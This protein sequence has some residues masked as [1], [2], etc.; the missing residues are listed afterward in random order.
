MNELRR[1]IASGPLVETVSRQE[2]FQVISDAASQNPLL[3]QQSSKRLKHMLDMFGTFDA[4][5]E[6]AAQKSLSLYIRQQAIIQFKNA[7]LGHWKS[8]KLLSDEHRG[9]IR[10]RSSSFIDEEDE[11]I[12][13]CNEVIVSKIARYD[14]PS[15]WPNLVADIMSIIDNNLQ[16]RYS[17]TDGETQST[18]VLR[19]SLQLLNAILKEFGSIKM[20]SGMKIMAELVEQLHLVLYNYYSKMAFSFSVSNVNLQNMETPYVY[21]N[22]LLAHLVFKC[23]VKIAVWL[24]S[25]MDKLTKEESEKNIAWFRELFES[26]AF[27]LQAL[28]NLRQNVVPSF[29]QPGP[30]ETLSSSKSVDILTRH[31]KAFGKFFRRL[32][33]LSRVRFIELPMCAD[34]ILFYWSQVVNATG[35]PSHYVADSNTAVYPVRFLVQ[36]MVLFKESLGQWTRTRRDGT[37]NRS[38]LSTEFVENAVKILITRFMP[39]NPSDLENWTRDPEEW[40]NLEDKENDQWEFEIRPCSER[41]L[42]QLSHQYSDIVTPLLASTF[43]DAAAQSTT[44]LPSVVQKEAL[45]CAIG[46]CAQRLKDVIPFNQWLHQTLAAEAQATNPNYPIIKRRI[47]WLLG[48]WV[49]ESCASPKDPTIWEILVHLLKDRNPGTDA[50]VRLTASIA[51]R[52]CIDTIEFD[53]EVFEPFLPTTVSELVRLMGEADTMESKGRINHTLNTV[54]EQSGIRIVPFINIITGPLP[55][56]W[57]AAGDDWLFKGSLLATVTRLVE[58]VKAN[59]TS[60]GPIIVPLVQES[61]SPGAISHLDEDGLNLWLNALRNTVTISSVDGA[62]ALI[63]LFPQAMELLATNL[64]LLGRITSIIESYIVLDAVSILQLHGI[65]LF[66]AF[67]AALKSD[68]VTINI[69]DMIVT[70]S[71]LI[72]ITPAALW[73]ESMYSSGLFAFLITTLVEGEIGTMLLTEYIYFFARIVMADRQMFLQLMVATASSTGLTEKYLFE[74]L[75]DQWWGKFDSMSEPRHRKLAAMGIACL[76]S[77]GRFE[78]LERLPTEIFNIWLDVFGE[79]KEIQLTTESDDGSPSPS[80]RNLRRYWELS[81][82]PPYYYQNTEGTPEYDRRKAIYENDPVRTM[83]LSVFVAN[84]LQEVEAVC[85]PA[86]FQSYLAKADPTVLKQIQ[87]ELTKT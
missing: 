86:V 6:I 17:S 35:G 45:Y 51:L 55:Q 84:R 64:D 5:Y 60:L 72:E 53:A 38:V 33:Q 13:E 65:D 11:T 70:L 61:L 20:P 19:R 52:E 71:I 48:K 54:I 73:G 82:A 15:K 18:L 36:G 27:Q 29:I 75:L 3:V 62:P 59:S 49:S 37:V 24:W 77:T 78:V 10:A 43:N 83:P 2:L 63:G 14:Y 34:L 1:N 44:D 39:L 66:R 56:L 57:T 9:W 21:D 28:V 80:P 58:S 67:L 46:R 32:Q 42:V 50:V 76:V 81:E 85:D 74:G 26:S 8:R 4:L 7:A 31:I 25:K 47:A 87:G 16:R 22:I 41:V 30:S 23:L 69:K 79:I 12:S 40:V 68:A